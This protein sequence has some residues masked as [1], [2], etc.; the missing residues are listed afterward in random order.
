[1]IMPLHSSLSDRV[2]PHLKKIKEKF[3]ETNDNGNTT[4]RNLWATAK[5][6]LGG[7]YIAVSAYTN[8]EEK[9]Q[10]NNLKTMLRN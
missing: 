7:N 10:K 5:A 2:R 1:M 4:Y 6:V 8:K 9:F 3:L